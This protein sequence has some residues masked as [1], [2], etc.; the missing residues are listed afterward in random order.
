MHGDIKWKMFSLHAINNHGHVSHDKAIWI[1]IME[2]K[3][4]IWVENKDKRA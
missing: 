2:E 1:Y 4:S 3:L